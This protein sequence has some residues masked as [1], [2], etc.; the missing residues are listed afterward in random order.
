GAGVPAQA[1][2]RRLGSGA[3]VQG[4]GLPRNRDRK[5]GRVRDQRVSGREGLSVNPRRRL[6]LASGLAVAAGAFGVRAFAQEKVIRI[7]ARKFE[8]VPETVELKQGEPVVLELSTA[9]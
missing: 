8:F 6:L 9:D 3:A 5:Q 7:T 1:R 2:P 4:P